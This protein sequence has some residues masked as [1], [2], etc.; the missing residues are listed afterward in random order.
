MGFGRFPIV[1]QIALV[2]DAAIRLSIH[3]PLAFGALAVVLEEIELGQIAM[4]MGFVAG[5][6][7]SG[8]A[9]F[10]G[11]EEVSRRVGMSVA[12][13]QGTTFQAD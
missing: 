3:Q 7:G 9:A 10:Q 1:S 5:M 8:N 6:M 13:N 12:A 11:R 4:Q 2:G